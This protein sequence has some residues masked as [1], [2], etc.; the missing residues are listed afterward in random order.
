MLRSISSAAVACTRGLISQ[1]RWQTNAALAREQERLEKLKQLG[2]FGQPTAA[3]H[4]GRLAD[5]E[6][7][8]QISASE[9]AARRAGVSA[10]ARLPP[11]FRCS[12]LP[13]SAGTVRRISFAC[14]RADPAPPP[15]ENARR[16]AAFAARM[17][18]DSVAVLCAAPTLY[19][20]GTAVP[21]PTAYRQRGNFL[22]LTGVTQP[23]C[24]AILEKPGGAPAP[25]FTLL[26]PPA[27]AWHTLW[28][29][30]R[31]APQTPRC[32]C[33]RHRCAAAQ[34]CHHRS[35]PPP[36]V[37]PGAGRLRALSSVVASLW[38]SQAHRR[39]R[40]GL[41]RGGRGGGLGP[42]GGGGRGGAVAGGQ[43]VHFVGRAAR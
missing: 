26:V 28:N 7:T 6:I 25:R 14:A 41:R 9:Y 5:D 39:R 40:R 24:V 18:P 12:L 23:G 16:R 33:H 4:P 27:D 34:R 17:P 32:C 22:Y 37:A 8:P 29:G 31:H 2:D 36:L 21:V 38:L 13:T 35:S 11:V 19:N 20:T 15:P 30:P 43:G 3:T 1:A 42:H 10:L